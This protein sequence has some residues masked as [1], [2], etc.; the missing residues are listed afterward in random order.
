MQSST[1]F[2]PEVCLRATEE[3]AVLS[4]TYVESI[5]LVNPSEL[6]H[7]TR[8][9]IN[10]GVNFSIKPVPRRCL[11]ACIGINDTPADSRGILYEGTQR[12]PVE[13]QPPSS[14][15]QQDLLVSIYIPR[16]TLQLRALA[17]TDSVPDL[18]KALSRLE[19][20]HETIVCI[21][22]SNYI[23][24]FEFVL[25]IHVY[26]LRKIIVSYLDFLFNSFLY[27]IDI[28][29]CLSDQENN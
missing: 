14:T 18:F 28:V 23:N 19:H 25:C 3:P 27:T 20:C 10:V 12:H 5:R 29:E 21:D 1:V 13:F 17:F 9:L 6:D 7:G 11:N 15:S 2:A 16:E 22:F 24:Y 8:E 26:A 4:V